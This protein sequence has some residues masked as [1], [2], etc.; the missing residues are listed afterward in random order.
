MNKIRFAANRETNYVFHMLSVA[1]CGY[2]NAYGA[3]YRGLYLPEDLSVIKR[4]EDLLMV[5]GGQHCGSL[6]G[7]LVARPACALVSVEDYYDR[8]IQTCVSIENGDIPEYANQALLPY[9][10][11]IIEISEVMIKYY[12]HFINKIWEQEKS[13]IERYI[14]ELL[15]LF[16]N[17]S[18]TEKAEKLVGRSESDYFTAMLVTSV[19]NGAEAIDISNDLD[20][21]GIERSSTDSFYFIAH[22]YIICLLKKAL[23]NANAFNC[24]ETWALT[25]GLAEYYIKKIVGDTRFFNAQQKYAEFYADISKHGDLSAS[26]LYQAALKRFAD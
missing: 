26:E 8:L 17:S 6:F 22:E 23:K 14:P 18:F 13:K 11:T 21:F 1:K 24:F 12:D 20:V 16:E 2:D 15:K 25:E 10:R 19:E 5:C 9:N 3:K 7:L 4:N